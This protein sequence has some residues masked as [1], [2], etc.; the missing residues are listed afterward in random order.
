MIVRNPKTGATEI[1]VT[2]AE[3]QNIY[4]DMQRER[5]IQKLFASIRLKMRQK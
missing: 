1:K 3:L 2:R 5:Q 4:S